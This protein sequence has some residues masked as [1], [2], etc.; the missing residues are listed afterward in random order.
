MSSCAGP[1]TRRKSLARNL[2]SLLAANAVIVFTGHLPA[3]K[4][5]SFWE[6][7]GRR[8]TPAGTLASSE[9][10]SP[11]SGQRRYF[12]VLTLRLDSGPRVASERASLH[13][14]S[15][16]RFFVHRGDD[17]APALP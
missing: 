15:L 8:K 2:P 17:P 10:Q 16:P 12:L 9:R 11:S 13:R 3:G 1:K 6:E 7:T 5:L 14:C 4:M